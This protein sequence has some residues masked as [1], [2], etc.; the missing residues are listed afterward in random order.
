MTGKNRLTLAVAGGRKTQSIVDACVES[1]KRRLIVTYTTNGQEE[2]RGRLGDACGTAAP[3]VTGWYSFLI[4][5]FVRP[6]LPAKYPER[7]VEGFNFHHDPHFRSYGAA[8]HFD[9]DGSLSKGGLSSLAASLAEITGGAPY[10]RLAHIY[11]EICFDEVQDLTGWDLEILQGLLSSPL[12]VVLVGDL[13][14]SVYD[15]NPRDKKNSPYRGLKMIEW[16]RKQEAAGRLCISESLDN[17]RSVPEVVALS[18]SIVPAQWGFGD[19]V[20]RQES[21]HVHRGLFR[22]TK[23]DVRTY[24]QLFD[25][26]T[27][28]WSTNLAQDLEEICRFQTMGKVKGVSID[29]VVIFPTAEMIK[30]LS[31]GAWSPKDQTVCKLYVAVTRARFS[32]AFILD[33]TVVALGLN[34]WSGSTL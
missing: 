34:S 5:H 23:E 17:W 13:R 14:Q 12:T 19:A 33:P 27:L 7:R 20:S 16:F 8:R 1:P 29:H 32:V 24:V 2:L 6:Y 3:E 31:S 26:L 22:L 10:D 9:K 15:T 28:R 30:F 11:Q 25:P 21:T 18:N 4:N